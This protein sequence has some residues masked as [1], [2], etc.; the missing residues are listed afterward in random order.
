MTARTVGASGRC[1]LAGLLRLALQYKDEKT[2][3]DWRHECGDEKGRAGKHGLA[4]GALRDNVCKGC[5]RPRIRADGSGVN[6][7]RVD[8]ARLDIYTP[9]LQSAVVVEN[10]CVDATMSIAASAWRGR[11]ASRLASQCALRLASVA[12]WRAA[13]WAAHHSF[14]L[15]IPSL[16]VSCAADTDRR[17]PNSGM[18]IGVHRHLLCFL[19][20]TIFCC[21]RADLLTA[22]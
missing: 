17:S 15:L 4:G 16:R 9:R 11:T 5:Q 18:S 13:L 19:S 1:L 14:M 10:A 12:S 6:S 7:G 8:G 2:K 20:A 21:M 22:C 3:N